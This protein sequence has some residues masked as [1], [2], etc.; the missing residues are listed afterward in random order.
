MTAEEI[1]KYGEDMFNALMRPNEP[2]ESKFAVLA[3]LLAEIAAQL[4]EMNERQ[5]K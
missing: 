3:Y 1:R 2:E 5:S 4:A